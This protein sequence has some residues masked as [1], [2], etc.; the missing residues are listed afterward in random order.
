[1][2]WAWIIGL[3]ITVVAPIAI[4]VW[5]A[6]A[7]SNRISFTMAWWPMLWNA[8]G[9]FFASQLIPDPIGMALRGH[10]AWATEE[11]LGQTHSATRVLSALGH[12]AADVV[13]PTAPVDPTLP[14][15]SSPRDRDVDMSQALSIP[16]ADG[17]TAIFIDATLEGFGDRKVELP[18]L[19][20]TGASFT[21]ISTQTA[22]DL[23]IAIPRDAPILTFNTASGP[24]ESR[25]VYLPALRLGDVR[26]DGLLVS[27][28]DGCVNSRHAG[29]LGQNVMRRF[30]VQID[31][32]SGETLLVPRNV[33]ARLNRAYDIEPMVEMELDGAPEVWLGRIRWV[34]VVHNR[35]TVPI[36]KVTPVVSFTDGP[37][38]RGK[39]IGRIEPGGTGRS[40]VEGRA[41]TGKVSS[42]GHY[43]LVLAEAYW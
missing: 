22:A 15:T 11:S 35:G 39:S 14:E 29:L 41:S 10:G 24:R 2:P 9:L 43:Q 12:Q 40:L 32:M 13:A 21:T 19:F 5:Q 20:D 7:D 42:K 36:N 28:C 6:G 8:S 17:G 1:M 26:V 16:M 38:L 23:G 37:S 18:Y 33:S 31:F 34:V 30:F 4:A 25:M 27:V 3:L